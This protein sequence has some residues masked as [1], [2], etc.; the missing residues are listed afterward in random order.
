MRVCVALRPQENALSFRSKCRGCVPCSES[1]L[2]WL[3]PGP[4]W[5]GL[6]R[7]SRRWING[8]QVEVP[9]AEEQVASIRHVL[10]GKPPGLGPRGLRIFGRS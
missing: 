8:S 5:R 4:L 2:V 7:L 10:A 3:R 1:T 9:V 6:W